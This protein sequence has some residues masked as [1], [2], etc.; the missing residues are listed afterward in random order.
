MTNFIDTMFHVTQSLYIECATVYQ[1]VTAVHVGQKFC[2]CTMV[3]LYRL[4]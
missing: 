4:A 1:V 3:G 2:T